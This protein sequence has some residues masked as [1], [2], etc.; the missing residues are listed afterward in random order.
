MHMKHWDLTTSQVADMLSAF[1]SDIGLVG[2]DLVKF[3][4]HMVYTGGVV[5]LSE[6]YQKIAA[7]MIVEGVLDF[8]GNILVTDEEL[9]EAD[10]DFNGLTK[11]E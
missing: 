8:S 4:S 10:E 1:E 2:S 9:Y 11:G 6:T 3:M 7:Y 5:F